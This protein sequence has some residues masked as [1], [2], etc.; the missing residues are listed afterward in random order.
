MVRDSI[1]DEIR[2]VR[3]SLAEKFNNDL[4]LIV[5][6]LQRQQR[7]SGRKYLTLPKREP[8]TV[9]IAEQSVGPDDDQC[10]S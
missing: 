6:D 7:E 9:E 1:T 8:Q 5:A 10:V 3:H 2:A 4:G